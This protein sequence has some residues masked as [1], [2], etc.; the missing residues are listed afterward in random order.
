MSLLR[1][2]AKAHSSA[3]EFAEVSHAHYTLT[4]L[5]HSLT[6]SHTH[7]LSNAPF[8]HAGTGGAEENTPTSAGQGHGRQLGHR[9]RVQAK[10]CGGGDVAVCL[11]CGQGVCLVCGQGVSVGHALRAHSCYI[12]IIA[13][14]MACVL[15]SLVCPTF[16]THTRAQV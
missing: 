7:D 2:Q 11:V 6:H 10:R 12:R 1:K 3:S 9:H 15:E 5:T 8:L 4:S 16:R 13:P 14:A